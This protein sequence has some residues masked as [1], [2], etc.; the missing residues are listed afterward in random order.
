M[1]ILIVQRKFHP[2]TLGWVQGLQGRGHDVGMLV[3]R[4]AIAA[5]ADA[6]E[7]HVIENI[8]W[9]GTLTGRIL[10][11]RSRVVIPRPIRLWRWIRRFDPDVVL[12]KAQG[13][14]IINQGPHIL[15]ASIIAALQGAQRISW[16]NR[17][18]GRSRGERRLARL[19][20]MPRVH[21]R[22]VPTAADWSGTAHVSDEPFVPYAAPTAGAVQSRALVP[23]NPI[24]ILTVGRFKA[25]RK[26][27]WW[28]LDA[29]ARAGL[30]D[31]RARFTFV[32]VGDTQ[33]EGYVRLQGVIEEHQC[34]EL[35]TVRFDVPY[36]EM[37]AVYAE[38]DLL[39]A[40]A[41]NEAFGMVVPEAM[42]YGLAVVA[43]SGVGAHSC[44]VPG[45]T[46]VVFDE[47]DIDSLAGALRDLITDPGRIGDMGGRGRAVATSQLSPD[48][49][50]ARI[51][52]L[53]LSGKPRR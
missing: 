16:G 1:R 41:R 36:D 34:A 39:V 52:E 50:A 11:G 24:R 8:R 12:L 38:H 32:G 10:P 49:C 26:R 28:T 43:S 18:E 20:L 9:L 53:A 45:E 37:E 25:M 17:A 30:L 2:N 13:N 27:P 31:G 19:K 48:S 29:A 14:S 21:L 33:A 35:V 23:E 4:E 42:V 44:V 51:E 3:S 47:G 15:S 46:G 6:C 40:P 7:I 5:P 22:T